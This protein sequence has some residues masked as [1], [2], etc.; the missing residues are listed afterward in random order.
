MVNQGDATLSEVAGGPNEKWN[1]SPNAG[2]GWANFMSTEDLL[3]PSKGYCVDNK[4]IFEAE[5]T[6]RTASTSSRV[7]QMQE[8]PPTLIR[9][10]TA[11][12]EVSVDNYYLLNHC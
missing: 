7:D 3:D 6:R 10:Q 2:K 8:A 12:L 4:L 9:D 5:I 11:L 1:P